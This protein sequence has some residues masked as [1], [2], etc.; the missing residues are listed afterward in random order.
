MGFG[1]MTGLTGL[2]NIARDYNLQF[3]VTHTRAHTLVSTHIFTSRCFVAASNDGRSPSSV[4]PND[5]QP[6]LPASHDD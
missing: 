3:T 4:F 2:F 6:Q 5:P 1:L